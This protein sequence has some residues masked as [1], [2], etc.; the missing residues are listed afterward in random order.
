MTQLFLF[1]VVIEEVAIAAVLADGNGG[2]DG[3]SN[4]AFH[5]WLLKTAYNPCFYSDFLYFRECTYRKFE[6]ADDE[7]LR[8]AELM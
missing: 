5:W 8:T 7:N 1:V 3:E 6:C 4:Q 2:K